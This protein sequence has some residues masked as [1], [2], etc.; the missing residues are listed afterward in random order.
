[1]CSEATDADSGGEGLRVHRVHTDD[2]AEL[3]VESRGSGPPLLLVASGTGSAAAWAPLATELATR[4]KVI[5]YDRRG[6][7]ASS[8]P[9]PLPVPVHRHADDAHQVLKQVAGGRGLV[10][11]SSAGGVISIELLVRHPAA[12]A[13]LVVHEPP[14]LR[15]A[16]TAQHSMR[17]AQSCLEAAASEDY[18]LA[19]HR[20][21]GLIEPPGHDLPRPRLAPDDVHEWGVL[22]HRD[23]GPIFRYLPTFERLRRTTTPVTV[24]NGEQSQGSP[25]WTATLALAER[26]SCTYATVPGGHLAPATMPAA[27]AAAL[28][29]MLGDTP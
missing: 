5:T 21:I 13:G 20:L 6:H 4:F 8:A 12:V 10:F 16:P 29:Q 23:W 7:F 14:V 3:H 17:I 11:G 24:T 15:L 26:L 1:V 28:R 25:V 18:E 2:G 19:L 9:T 27:V 22:F